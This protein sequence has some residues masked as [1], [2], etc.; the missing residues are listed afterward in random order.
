LPWF[1]AVAERDHLIQNPTSP[2][3]IRRL[4]ELLSLGPR[5][6][7]L[8]VA[9]GRGGPAVILG[10]TF[11]CRILCVEQAPEFARVAQ[12][13]IAEAGISS[14]I[15][16]VEADAKEIVLEPSAFDAALCLGAS[17]I[18]DGLGG[19]LAELAAAV[20]PRGHVVVGE[21]FWRAWPLPAGIDDEGFV[22]LPRT[23]E[24]F[25]TAGLVVEG[26]IASSE[27]DW[28]AYESLHWRAIE[29][30]LAEH[31]EDADA[32]EIQRRHEEARD[33]YLTFQ[34]ELLG[35]AMFVARKRPFRR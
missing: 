7:V 10:E 23:V 12:E 28:D 29:D 14:L 32:E 19:T 31:P 2:E 18:W 15:E 34:R 26:I 5:S 25:R 27:D 13:R 20:R 30:W 24:R 6:R 3:K 8:D 16:V 22:D 9:S 11:G 17:F 21:P 1:F 4:G 33:R 35:W